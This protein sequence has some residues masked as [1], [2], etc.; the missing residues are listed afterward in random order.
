MSVSVITTC[1]SQTTRVSCH[2]VTQYTAFR[3]HHE[4]SGGIVTP[5]LVAQHSS[6]AAS[7]RSVTCGRSAEPRE[8]DAAA[9]RSCA[10]DD[11][12]IEG[13][14]CRQDGGWPGPAGAA[15][16][17]RAC[18]DCVPQ[19]YLAASTGPA[20]ALGRIADKPAWAAP[21]G[22]WYRRA[23]GAKISATLNVAM[24]TSKQGGTAWTPTPAPGSTK[25]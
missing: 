5:F 22:S 17:R 3:L 12:K 19:W 7:I 21:L 10:C 25:Q 4:R 23:G 8:Q 13:S 18:G 9:P 2:E 15:D 11:H 1:S 24:T 6:T 14:C 20:L 16:N